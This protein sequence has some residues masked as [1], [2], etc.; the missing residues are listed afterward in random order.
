MACAEYKEKLIEAALDP[1]S[2]AVHEMQFV[3]HV[4]TCAACRAELDR[5]RALYEQIEDG[6]AALVGVQAPA[7]IAARVRQE[8]AAE[9]NSFTFRNFGW[10]SAAA[11]AA[12]AV[13][14]AVMMRVPHRSATNNNATAANLS[15][16]VA[17]APTSGTHSVDRQPATTRTPHVAAQIVH[18]VTRVQQPELIDEAVTAT[19]GPPRLQ[20]IVPAGQR[21]AV[22]RLAAALQTGRVD[23][24]SLIRPLESFEPAELKIAPL[25]IKPLVPDENDAGSNPP[26]AKPSIRN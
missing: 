3:R 5:Q 2:D 25:E 4:E 17:T 1:W 6:V 15:S 13:A 20:V 26:D 7:A 24:A 22:L 8:I 23:A 16:R 14:F 10:L 12:I 11:V 9:K 19:I 18:A 21:E